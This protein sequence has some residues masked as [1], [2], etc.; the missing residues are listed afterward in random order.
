M[1][2]GNY[3]E[4]YLNRGLLRKMTGNFSGALE[5]LNR[6]I[7]AAP[8][9]AEIYKNRGNLFLLYGYHIHA[10]A[11][12]TKAI[13]LEGEYAEAY[14]NR[15]LAQFLIYDK[16]SGCYDLE[17]AEKYGYKRAIEK[18]KYFCVD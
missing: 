13:D 6:V 9:N 5:D 16:A 17:Q 10:I 8:T 7:K 11:D 1:R 18:K 14:F 4:A 3:L 2:G 15:G 12:Y